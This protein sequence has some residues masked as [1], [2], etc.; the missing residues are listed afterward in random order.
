MSKAKSKAKK[1]SAEP[2]VDEDVEEHQVESVEDLPTEG[3]GK[4][5]YVNGTVYEG[6]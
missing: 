3:Y 4:F 1:T 5:K 2:E 6:Q